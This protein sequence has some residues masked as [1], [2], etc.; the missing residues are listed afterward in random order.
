M[1]YGNIAELFLEPRYTTYSVIK[2]PDPAI[3]ASY[4]VLMRPALSLEDFFIRHEF[5]KEIFCD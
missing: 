2:L 1:V 3:V 4:I 5:Y